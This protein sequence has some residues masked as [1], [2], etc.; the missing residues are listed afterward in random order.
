MTGDAR[1]VAGYADSGQ[2][3]IHEV[4]GGHAARKKKKK[5]VRFWEPIWLNH[6]C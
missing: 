2:T 1:V 4:M 3:G 6:S 5:F